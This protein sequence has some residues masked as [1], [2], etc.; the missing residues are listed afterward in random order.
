[1]KKLKK[2]IK[3]SKEELKRELQ[4]KINGTGFCWICGRKEF[5][6]RHHAIPQRVLAPSMNLTIPICENCVC[7]IHNGD[8]LARI[9][10]KIFMK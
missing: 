5:L 1:M 9:I 2:E 7:V 8:D 10:K 6:T 3:I 4:D